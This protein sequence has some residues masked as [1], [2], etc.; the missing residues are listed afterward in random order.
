[1]TYADAFVV[2]AATVIEICAYAASAGA[3]SLSVFVLNRAVV[4]LIKSEKS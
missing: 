3:L 2:V 1:M 4:V